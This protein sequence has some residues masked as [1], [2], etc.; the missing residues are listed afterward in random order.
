MKSQ[1]A[2]A[3]ETGTKNAPG[4]VKVRKHEIAALFDYL[5]LDDYLSFGGQA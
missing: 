5:D 1:R 4:C 3:S 2:L